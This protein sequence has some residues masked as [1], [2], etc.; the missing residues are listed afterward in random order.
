M[1]SKA[2]ISLEELSQILAETKI[3]HSHEEYILAAGKNLSSSLEILEEPKLEPEIEEFLASLSLDLD[4]SCILEYDETIPDI[5]IVDD[6]ENPEY[7]DYIE[8]W[9]QEVVKLEYHSFLQQFLL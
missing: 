5:Y 4:S 9:F 7:K 1:N 3:S 6:E 8:T 2:V